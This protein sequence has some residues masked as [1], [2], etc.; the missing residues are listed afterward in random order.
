MMGSHMSRIFALF[1]FLLLSIQN[2]NA[3]AFLPFD[4]PRPIAVLLETNPW[5]MVVGSDTPSF[6]LYEDGQVI[7]RKISAKKEARYLWKLLTAAELQRLK[8]RLASFGPYSKGNNRIDIAEVSDQPETKLYLNFEET[9]LVASIYGINFVNETRDEGRSK[10]PLPAELRKLYVFLSSLE[11]K[12]ATEWTPK[13]IEAIAWNYDHAVDASVSWPKQWP[14]LNSPMTIKNSSTY[15]IFI[16]AAELKNVSTFLRIRK[17][18]GAVE[19]DGKKFAVS[20]RR[21]FPSEPVWRK[22]FSE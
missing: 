8:A 10:T 1:L 14:G 19:I 17:E 12:D 9:R 22:A 21:V 15:S 20:V 18:K 7:Y 5:L 13:Y 4:G 2:A 3:K 16:P 6:V 11:F